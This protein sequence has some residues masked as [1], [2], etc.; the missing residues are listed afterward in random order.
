MSV[1]VNG[2]Q[3]RHPSAQKYDLVSEVKKGSPEAVELDL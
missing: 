3:V 1:M 2:V